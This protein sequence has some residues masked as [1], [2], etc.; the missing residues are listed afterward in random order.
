MR[1]GGAGREALPGGVA[2]GRGPGFGLGSWGAAG[3]GL[4]LAAALGV[5]VGGCA[6]SGWFGDSPGKG[7]VETVAEYREPK[8][9]AVRDGGLL[10]EKRWSRSVAS[11]ADEHF[12]HPGH[13][14]LEGKDLFVATSQGEVVRV[15][16]R[17]GGVHWRVD[18]E[19]G[20]SGGVA[21]AAGR[22]FVGN[23]EGVL[24]ALDRE[25]G[26]PLWKRNVGSSVSSA[27]AV[28]GER[29][30]VVTLDGHVHA[31]RTTDGEPL[32]VHE[33][34][35]E[36]QVVMGSATPVMDKGLVYVGL[37][38]GEVTALSQQDG[39][40][41]WSHNLSQSRRG[42]EIEMLRDVDAD[43]VL[44]PVSAPGLR[45]AYAVSFQ[46]NMVALHAESGDL[47][48]ERAVSAIRRPLILNN[49]LIVP[50]LEGNLVALSADDGVVLWKTR[51]SDGL[52]T[53]PVEYRGKIGVADGGGRLFVVEPASGRVLGMER[54]GEAILADP[55]V[56]HE[57][58]YL[59]SNEGNVILV[60]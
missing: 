46:G 23:R 9:A 60:H 16:A 6:P 55:M 35:F 10:L 11:E 7:K 17:D 47:L 41:K 26:K 24:L 21:L 50:D 48:W 45:M 30:V 1:G 56:A 44:M 57:G 32:W 37:A 42:G 39:R 36:P 8:P 12:S 31:F 5:V 49:Q 14:V 13:S 53:A 22:L 58:I 2:C 52:L 43:V 59:W 25:S 20:I 27:P 15:D 38:S 28:A 51:L 29:L 18:T 40:P 54:L 34:P 33:S 4:V 19:G 3:R